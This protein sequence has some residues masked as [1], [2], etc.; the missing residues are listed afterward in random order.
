MRR[1]GGI[2]SPFTM[3]LPAMTE[4][5][6]E[7]PTFWSLENHRTIAVKPRIPIEPSDLCPD[8]KPTVGFFRQT[9]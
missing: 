7:S 2:S 9:D 5:G 6:L 8:Q 3:P 1:G 4:Q